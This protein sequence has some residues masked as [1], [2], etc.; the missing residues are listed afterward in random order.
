MEKRLSQKISYPLEIPT[1]RR[2][3]LRISD[4]NTKIKDFVSKL[5]DN[6]ILIVKG[7][8]NDFISAYKSIMSQIQIQMTKLR[9]N[10]DDQTV[11]VKNDQ[12]VRNLQETLAWYQ[13]EAVKL[14]DACSRLQS[15]YDRVKEKIQ[16]FTIE[17]N[18]LEQQIKMLIR[19]NQTLKNNL[20]KKSPQKPQTTDEIQEKIVLSDTLKEF[21]YKYNIKNKSLLQSLTSFFNSIENIS[22]KEINQIDLDI[23]DIKFNI[24]KISA[25]QSEVYMKRNESEELFLECIDEMRKEI[26]RKKAKTYSV[27]RSGGVKQDNILIT[28]RE[29]LIESFVTNEETISFLYDKL[30]PWKNDK[31]TKDSNYLPGVVMTNKLLEENIIK[32]SQGSSRSSN[33]GRKGIVIKGKL[34]I[35]D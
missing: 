12:A 18:Y 29:K 30:F 14:S 4:Y 26:I 33:S 24:H 23:K 21:K 2:L 13:N 17:N 31:V 25:M 15:R 6:I 19:Q 10:S 27:K 35:N 16:N 22:N 3:D 11:M 7:H 28:E 34:M 5:D 8:E 32:K 20:N 9:Q 1:T